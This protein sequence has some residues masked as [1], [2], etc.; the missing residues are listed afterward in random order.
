MAYASRLAGPPPGWVV[1]LSVEPLEVPFP[2]SE[3]PNDLRPGPP[4][5]F[6]RVGILQPGTCF[7]FPY[8]VA[9]KLARRY[10]GL[11]PD[12]SPWAALAAQ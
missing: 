1:D 4:Y 9:T 3:L 12:G 11:W 7:P 8:D 6:N 5:P 2:V 10:S